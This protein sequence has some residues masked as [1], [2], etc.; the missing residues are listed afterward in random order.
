[1][2]DGG[3]RYGTAAPAAG[4]APRP[5]RD[6]SA[7]AR[8]TALNAHQYTRFVALMKRALP[9]AASLLIGAVLVF[10]FIPRQSDKITMAYQQLGR[11]D[12]DLAMIKPRLS[13]TD[14]N[15]NPF[16]IT[17]DVAV[18]DARHTRRARLKN[19]QADMSLDAQ[20]WVNASADAGLFDMTAGSLA[21]T[22][23]ISVF[24][25]SGYE[26]HTEDGTFN[27]RT[28]VFRGPHE[29]KGQGPLGNFR[30]DRFELWRTTRQV[31]L[32][33]NV[34]MTMYVQNSKGKHE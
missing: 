2:D 23:G 3:A 7:R 29:V 21:L 8:E 27:L 4:T 17:A 19:I 18:Q 1:M 10:S 33:G 28:G 9:I 34:H 11:I 6:W 31:L 5:R 24:S 30:A 12:N 25:D 16:V 14:A 20:R 15:G 22:G 32:A 26:L 13:G